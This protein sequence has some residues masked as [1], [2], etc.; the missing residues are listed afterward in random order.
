M[1][2]DLPRTPRKSPK[3]L[4]PAVE[5]LAGPRRVAVLG[6]AQPSWYSACIGSSAF[7]R[8]RL[9]ATGPRWN[10]PMNTVLQL[11]IDTSKDSLVNCL[12]GKNPKPIE[13]AV[14]NSVEGVAQLLSQLGED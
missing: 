8:L 10:G 11:G 9:T 6:L 12:V 3:G 7:T 13:F 14:A 4:S 1:W 5:R 2:L